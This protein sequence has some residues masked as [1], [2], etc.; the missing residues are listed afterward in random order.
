[1]ARTAALLANPSVP[2]IFEAAFEHSKVRVRV[3]VL[4]RMP[5]GYWGIREASVAASKGALLR[6]D[7]VL[8]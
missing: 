6:P 1:M 8:P 3:D 2:A 5:R 4:E 7:A